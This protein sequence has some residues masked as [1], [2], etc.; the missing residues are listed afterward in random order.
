MNRLLKKIGKIF[1]LLLIIWV[2]FII[3]NIGYGK[4]EEYSAL[5]SIAGGMDIKSATEYKEEWENTSSDIIDMSKWDKYEAGLAVCN[6]SDTDGDGL[7]DK[8]EI[9]IY[10]SDPLKVSTAD[11]L[12]T[13]YY[14]VSNN[15]DVNRYY[16]YEGN[17]IYAYNECTEVI[18]DAQIPTD[19]NAVV[20]NHTGEHRL[21]GCKVYAEYEVYNYSGIFAVD[22]S[23]VLNGNETTVADIVVYV[24]DGTDME[25]YAYSSEGNMIW[26]K[27]PLMPESDYR[28]YVMEKS[29]SNDIAIMFGRSLPITFAGDDEVEGEGLVIMFPMF[30]HDFKIPAIIYYEDLHTEENNNFRRAIFE[31]AGTYLG[32]DVCYYDEDSCY[33]S[34]P[35]EIRIRYEMLNRLLPWFDVTEV[36]QGDWKFWQFGFLYYSYAAKLE[37]EKARA[38]EQAYTSEVTGFNMFKDTLPFGN[39]QTE[40]GS[41]GNCA[42]IAHLTSYL[43]NTGSY[44]KS[45]YYIDDKNS[46]QWDIGLDPDNNTL[47]DKELYDYKTESFV[48]DHSAEGTVL[49]KDLSEGEKEFVN[50]IGA[51]NVEGNKIVNFVYTELYGGENSHIDYDYALVESMVDYLEQKK[52]LDVYLMMTD[53]TGHAVNIYGY[54]KDLE[55]ENVIWFNVYDCNFSP[56]S[57]RETNMSEAGFYLK[58]EKKRNANGDGYTFDYEYFPLETN[59]YGATSNPNISEQSFLIVLDENGHLLND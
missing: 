16:E 21:N 56:G 31:Y 29:I 12:Y 34:S 30:N 54:E 52:I 23:D 35:I 25:K 47:L 49:E 55:D 18:L 58:T 5:K 51:A 44:E 11:D 2:I 26:L 13:D 6:G 45:G 27:K 9:E 7:T 32:E 8:E 15:M 36:A 42:G 20:I 28:V 40:Y 43:F 14:K 46:I 48:A 39:F 50:M 10:D 57:L 3:A 41:T 19:F 33:A 59:K 22:L 38:E 53:G 4:Y 37:G 24:S 1:L 17:A